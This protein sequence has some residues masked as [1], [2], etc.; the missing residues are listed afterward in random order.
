MELKIT[1]GPNPDPAA[2]AEH[3]QWL[4]MGEA[5]LTTPMAIISRTQRTAPEGQASNLTTELCE[6]LLKNRLA[7]LERRLSDGRTY[8][9]GEDFTIA[10]ISVGYALGY[11]RLRKMDGLLGA[12]ATA[13]LGRIEARPAYQRAVAK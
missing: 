6:Q 10:D 8:V 9:T 5:S 2:Y 12:N 4:H 11:A 1:V 3:L 13:Y 7:T